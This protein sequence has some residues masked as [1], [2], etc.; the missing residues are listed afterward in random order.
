VSRYSELLVARLEVS[1]PRSMRMAW[2]A[3][4]RLS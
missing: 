2:A 1:L 4:K 3:S